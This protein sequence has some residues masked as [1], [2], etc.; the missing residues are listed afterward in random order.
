MTKRSRGW[1]FID[2]LTALMIVAILAAILGA[3]AASRQRAMQHLAD[4]RSA[5]RAAEAAIIS[6]QS[7]HPAGDGVVVHE[8]STVSPIDGK[9]WVQVEATVNHRQAEIVGLVPKG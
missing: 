2:V 4:S 1:V 3:A 6:L 5:Q 7:G 8:L 9:I